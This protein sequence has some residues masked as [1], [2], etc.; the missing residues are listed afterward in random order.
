MAET[1]TNLY[2]REIQRYPLLSRE[3]ETA[4]ARKARAGD[5]SAREK[6]VRSNLR[7]VVNI[8]KRYVGNGVTFEDLINE[9]NLGLLKA[10]D[11]FDPERGYKFISYAVWWI[12]QSILSAVSEDSRMVR[13]PMNRVALAHRATKAAR[14]LEQQLERMPSAAEIAKEISARPD[15]VEEVTIH[16]R[17]HLSLDEP[18][19]T[20]G[21]DTFADQ[22]RDENAES[23]D[24]A[25]YTERLGR[26]MHRML[27]G[28]PERERVILCNYYG[29]NG[30]RPRTLEEIG[31]ELGY[32]RE[33]IRQIKEQAIERLRA[34]PRA[35]CMSDYLSA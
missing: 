33:R 15:E 4:L 35:Q 5:S 24:A 31:R 16:S 1:T 9:G 21:D 17:A 7:F 12:R 2:L 20:D 29:I 22:L 19:G 30:R 27:Q 34:R 14:T 26:D 10:A 13:L 8:A 25:V 23:P 11:R 3:E 18:A 6:L 32:T 28:L